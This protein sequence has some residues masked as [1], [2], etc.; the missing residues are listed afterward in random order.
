MLEREAG[1]NSDLMYDNITPFNPSSHI[2]MNSVDQRGIFSH[3]QDLYGT[4]T[5]LNLALDLVSAPALEC[6]NPGDLG[7]MLRQRSN[8]ELNLDEG[9]G[10]FA[11]EQDLWGHNVNMNLDNVTSENTQNQG[12][13]IHFNT[14]LNS[15]FAQE[16]DWDTNPLS[17][18]V[19]PASIFAQEKD[20]LSVPMINLASPDGI[21]SRERD[22][23]GQFQFEHAS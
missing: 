4:T 8:L 11:H 17:N 1:T 5:S 18:L 2:F 23:T 14:T 16:Q 7:V 21:F 13:S 19:Q 15:V 10:I 3:E 6:N 12:E 20:W 22:L 9:T